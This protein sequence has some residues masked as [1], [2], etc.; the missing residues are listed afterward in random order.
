MS[1][2]GN[3]NRVKR[4]FTCHYNSHKQ[5]TNKIKFVPL[6][7]S[8][9]LQLFSLVGFFSWKKNVKGMQKCSTNSKKWRNFLNNLCEVFA[10]TKS[11]IC[12]SLVRQYFFVSQ[13]VMNC[14]HTHL[15]SSTRTWTTGAPAKQ[16]DMFLL[17]L[18]VFGWF[19]RD[20]FHLTF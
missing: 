1:N 7:F 13:A 20:E 8:L 6:C 17:L 10:E 5:S 18:K 16:P 2:S 19:V 14:W 15:G 12:C 4:M 9:H 3:Q 11:D